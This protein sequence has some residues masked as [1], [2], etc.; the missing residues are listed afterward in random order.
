VIDAWRALESRY[1]ELLL[2][3]VPRRPERF[4]LAAQKLASAGVPFVRRSALPA[5]RR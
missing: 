3:L 1:P 4:D 5:G 2:I